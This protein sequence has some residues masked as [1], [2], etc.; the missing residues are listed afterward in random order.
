[1]PRDGF[2]CSLNHCTF[3]T[4]VEERD[5][6][7]GDLL[8]AEIRHVGK[9]AHCPERFFQFFKKETLRLPNTNT[10]TMGIRKIVK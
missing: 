1:M 8:H 2:N 5:R 3:V 6:D 10:P 9:I 4:Y 7:F